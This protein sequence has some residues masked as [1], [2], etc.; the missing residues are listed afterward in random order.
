MRIRFL[1]MVMVA[2]GLKTTGF[3]QDIYNK[4][5]PF[6]PASKSS[7]DISK[8]EVLQFSLKQSK[9]YP[10]TSRSY[11]VYIPAEY[12]PE[13][14]ACLFVCMDGIMFNAPT[15]FD[16]LISKKEMPITIGVFIQPGTI[17]K[18]D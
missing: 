18:D 14:A 9:L 12:K 5:Y 16:Y 3:T 13:N 4:R 1:L 10:G 6:E 17:M 7:A 2:A 8:G 15:V 11:W